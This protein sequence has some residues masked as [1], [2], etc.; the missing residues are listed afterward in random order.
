MNKKSTAQYEYAAR[1]YNSRSHGKSVVTIITTDI[2][3]TMNDLMCTIPALET[4]RLI[5]SAHRKTDHKDVAALWAD[6]TVTHYIMAGQRSTSRDSWMR[7]LSYL[8]LWPLL[9]YGYWAVRDKR[10]GRYMGDIGFADFYREL[11]TDISQYP[12]A[13]WVFAPW[14]QGQGYAGEALDAILNWLKNVRGINEC[15]C[16]I[17]PDNQ[18][19]VNLAERHGFRQKEILGMDY[20][21]VILYHLTI[22]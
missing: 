2:K 17:S 14:A 12:E 16:I 9:G 3:H 21:S 19:S 22:D 6:R 4:D 1:W 7:M 8:G 10:T 20:K 18:P 11:D 5:L 15:V 13:G